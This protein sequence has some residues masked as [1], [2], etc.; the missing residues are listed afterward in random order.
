MENI[1]VNATLGQIEELKDSILWAD[2]VQELES[3]K[4]GFAMEL[5]SIVDQA[6]DTNPTTASVLLHIG[7]I[8]GRMKAVDYMASI[9]D[10]FIGILE[11]QKEEKDGRTNEE[12]E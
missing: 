10:I 1:T 9:L 8:N 4:V 2:I 3:W 11:T 6:A 7:D 12:G 5:E